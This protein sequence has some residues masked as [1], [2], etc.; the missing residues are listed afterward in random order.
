[1]LIRP[2]R[3]EDLAGC[4]SLLGAVHTSDG[5]PANW[6]RNPTDWLVDDH[7]LAAWVAEDHGTLLGHIA[8]NTV[9]AS[10]AWPEWRE[11]C[12]PS[13]LLASVS[14]LF[15]APASRERKIGTALITRAEE[16]AT[17]LGRPLVLDVAEHN[18]AAIRLYEHRGWRRVG[19]AALP[20]GDDGIALQLVLFVAPMQPLM[21]NT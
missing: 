7:G 16:Q 6:P 4:V 8:L 20:A 18:R 14:R 10:C 13:V 9:S 11:A 12:R 17:A 2:R 5:Y 19:T 1:V 15:V 21:T 3:P